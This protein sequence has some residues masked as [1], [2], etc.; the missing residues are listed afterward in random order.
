LKYPDHPWRS[1][2]YKDFAGND[3]PYNNTTKFVVAA[4]SMVRFMKRYLNN[5]VEDIIN[6]NGITDEQ[7]ELLA[8]RFTN[9]GTADDEIKRRQLWIEAIA[10]GDFG[11]PGERIQYSAD[12][13]NSWKALAL[14]ATSGWDNQSTEYAYSESFLTSDWKMF[15]DAL[16][17]HSFYVLHEL[18]PRFGICLA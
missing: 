3:I 8:E 18:L 2:Q 1:W 15:H 11:F 7:K 4:D 13:P 16:Q 10:R 14:Q 5:D 17:A 9:Y 12:G 6:I